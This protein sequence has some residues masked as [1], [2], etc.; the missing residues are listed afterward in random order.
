MSPEDFDALERELGFS[1]PPYY[2]ETLLNY[3]FGEGSVAQE[4][5]LTDS[6]TDLLEMNAPEGREGMDLG[7]LERPFFIGDDCGEERY[8]IDAAARDSRVYVYQLEADRCTG[9]CANWE[10]YLEGIRKSDA[11]IAE[12]ERLMAELE[13]TKKWWQFWR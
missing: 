12:D 2:R 10:A 3:P 5:E 4:N 13:A 1:L 6:L 11:D 7:V 8:L 9:L